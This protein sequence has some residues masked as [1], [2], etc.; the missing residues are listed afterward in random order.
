M[1]YSA[2]V[3][4]FLCCILRQYAEK[5]KSAQS[6][7][8]G[9]RT[10]LLSE[11]DAWTRTAEKEPAFTL[12][13]PKLEFCHHSFALFSGMVLPYS[14]AW[15]LYQIFDPANVSQPRIF[16]IQ[17]VL[18][19]LW[20][21]VCYVYGKLLYARVKQEEGDLLPAAI[22]QTTQLLVRFLVVIIVWALPFAVAVIYQHEY[23]YAVF[24]PMLCAQGFLN[25]IAYSVR[26]DWLVCGCFTSNERSWDTTG[27]LSNAPLYCSTLINDEIK[28]G[29]QIGIGSTAVVYKC[30]F[31]NTNAALKVE[32][33]C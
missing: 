12:K 8:E 21:C 27:D 13:I 18:F 4:Y 10:A 19:F 16:G 25:F 9:L 26:R 2:L 28:I 3:G 15:F 1:G 24:T 31:A 32:T 17:I 14:P 23:L 11:P 5:Q 22:T 29:A 30:Q 20:S 6:N 33:I 7:K